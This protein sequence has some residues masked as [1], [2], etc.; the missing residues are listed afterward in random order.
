V[1]GVQGVLGDAGVAGGCA[2]ISIGILMLLR[3]EAKGETEADEVGTA[4]EKSEVPE[5]PSAMRDVFEKS[6]SGV[7][8]EG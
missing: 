6:D 2:A 3:L 5:Q 7:A 1:R 4:L 8:V